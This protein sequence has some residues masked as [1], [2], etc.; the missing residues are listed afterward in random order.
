VEEV[1]AVL[2]ESGVEPSSLVLEITETVMMHGTEANLV[3]LH[4]LRALGVRLAIDD[5]GTGY[6]SLSYL[7]RF[8]VDIIKIDKSFVDGV[9]R[10]GSE[11]A[12]ARTIVALGDTLALRC[13]AEGVEDA[14]Q[15]DHLRALGCDFAQGFLFARP[16]PAGEMDAV[17]AAGAGAALWAERR[18]ARGRVNAA[19]AAGV[20][21]G[22]PQGNPPRH[23]P[24]RTDPCRHPPA[25]LRLAAALMLA[26]GPALAAAQAARQASR[27]DEAR[28]QT[29]DQ[30]VRHVLGRLAFGARPG[31]E[32]RVRAM[33]VDRWIAGQLHPERLDDAALDRALAGLTTVG[34]PGAELLERFPPPRAGAGAARA[35]RPHGRRH[36]RRERRRLG[37][38]ARAGAGV[39]PRGGRAA[40]VAR[41]PRGGQRAAAAGGDA[42]LL[43]QPLQR[44]RRQGPRALLPAGVRGDAARARAG[45]LPR[46]A[47]RGAKSPAML[48]YLDN[49]QSVADS[50]R[51][52]LGR[53][54]GQLTPRQRARLAERDPQAAAMLEQAARRRPRGLNENYARELLEL[55]TLGVDGGYTQQDV[56]EVARALTGWTLRPPAQGGRFRFRPQVHDAAEKTVL[57]TRFPAGRGIE[58][59]EQVLDIV[60]RHPSTATFIARKLAVR[61]VS[62]SPPPALVARAAETFRSTDGDLRA[63]LATIVESPEFFARTAYRA[64][65]KTP[66]ELVASA[67]RALGASVDT[68][69]RTAQLIARLGQP[70]LRAPAPGRLSGDAGAR[71]EPGCDPQP[72]QLRLAC[73]GEPR[74]GRCALADCARR[75]REQ[76]PAS[77]ATQSRRG[78]ACS[79]R[80]LARHARRGERRAPT[81]ARAD[82]AAARPRVSPR[83]DADRAGAAQRDARP[84][85]PAPRPASIPFAQLVW[86]AARRARVP[87]PLTAS[88]RRYGD[89]PCNAEPS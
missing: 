6:S 63:T 40:G 38:R 17:V 49:W 36:R 21:R 48:Q 53:R 86:L 69:P 27:G 28:E 44:V 30:Q 82:R 51:P 13:I 24:S 52:T 29:A 11:A 5:F 85:S 64:K 72:H 14:D 25:R 89:P 68:T 33:G 45:A 78:G 83:R 55:H 2:E 79:R 22:E 67:A 77:P 75:A 54:P 62:D 84:P 23:P 80:D 9:A 19:G 39:V 73:A 76:W 56:I 42:R 12:L 1:A 8:P 34:R 61:F 4:A 16:M 60:A 35:R 71:D 47:G 18:R 74:A 31:D 81:T 15:R 88:D 3:T 10:G 7:Q 37:G 66:F 50:G 57:G 32:A 41:R 20:P 65:V 58:D 46:P 87:A 70:I 43:G 26:A 59:G